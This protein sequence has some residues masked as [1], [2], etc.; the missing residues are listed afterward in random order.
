MGVTLLLVNLCTDTA[1]DFFSSC[2]SGNLLSATSFLGVSRKYLRKNSVA[3]VNT[4]TQSMFSDS[5]KVYIIRYEY[6]LGE[7]ITIPADCVLKF[8]GGRIGGAFTMTGKNTLVKAK[9]KQIFET[10]IKLAGTWTSSE[11]YPEWFGAKG[12][13]FTDDRDS[14]NATLAVFNNVVLNGKSTYLIS[15]NDDIY[16]FLWMGIHIRSNTVI[17][18]NGAT[19]KAIPSSC[20]A[21]SIVS[22]VEKEDVVIRNVNF[23]GDSDSHPEQRMEWGDGVETRSA[24]NVRIEHCT[25]S[26][27]IADGILIAEH[28]D[29]SRH[30]SSDIEIVDCDIFTYGRNGIS[31]IAGDGVR[32]SNCRIG[33]AIGNWAPFGPWSCIDIE[34]DYATQ[35]VTNID[36]VGCVFDNNRIVNGVNSNFVYNIDNPSSSSVSISD[37]FG[38]GAFSVK[39]GRA[40]QYNNKHSLSITSCQMGALTYE[41]KAPVQTVVSNCRINHNDNHVAIYIAECVENSSLVI[42]DCVV[43]LQG[44]RV[45]V[46]DGNSVFYFGQ[47]PK[48]SLYYGLVIDGI[49]VINGSIQSELIHIPEGSANLFDDRCR[50]RNI[51][52]KCPVVENNRSVLANQV[53]PFDVS[54]D[55]D[56]L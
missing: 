31:V 42:K 14:F 11:S 32:I 39:G 20:G 4:L 55:C 5:N 54:I 56:F 35:P 1:T 43:D 21:Y 51:R 30:Y 28:P 49:D 37:C 27:F 52:I 10:G 53:I 24:K 50:V 7:D 17:E 23:Q 36:I 2:F 15:S 33:T 3:G 16:P 45:G 26:G 44:N 38:N 25:F 8:R 47:L 48:S 29:L 13:S 12:N 9:R 46:T 18:G 34:P 41:S 40:N 19:L 6:I 22:V